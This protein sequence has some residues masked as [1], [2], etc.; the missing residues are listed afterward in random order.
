MCKSCPGALCDG[1]ELS[2]Y[3]HVLTKAVSQTL[4]TDKN[5]CYVIIGGGSSTC[6]DGAQTGAWSCADS[7]VQV[8]ASLRCVS[9]WGLI[10]TFKF[11]P[12]CF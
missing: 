3:D 4:T 6:E 2:E 7:G 10:Q 8:K 5:Q 9:V 11:F 1:A 12:S